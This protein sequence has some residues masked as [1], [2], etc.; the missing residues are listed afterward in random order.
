M[1]GFSL[2]GGSILAENAGRFREGRSALHEQECTLDAW[3]TQDAFS[4]ADLYAQPP[5]DIL[6]HHELSLLKSAH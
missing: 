3:F 1:F 5:K 4:A 2:D 6:T